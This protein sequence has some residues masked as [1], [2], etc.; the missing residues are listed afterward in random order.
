MRAEAGFEVSFASA[1]SMFFDCLRVARGASDADRWTL[2]SLGE[3]SAQEGEPMKAPRFLVRWLQRRLIN[4]VSLRRAPDVVI[5]GEEKPYLR[6]WFVIPRNPIFN[7]YLHHFLRSD[8]DRALHD[9]PW[10]NCSLLLDGRYLEHTIK[11]GGVNVR[12]LRKAGDIVLRGAKAAHRVELMDPDHESVI[13]IERRPQPCWTLFITG[14]RVREWAFTVLRVGFIGAFSRTLKTA[15]ARSAR[16]VGRIEMRRAHTCWIYE[17]MVEGKTRVSALPPSLF[18]NSFDR[19]SRF[20]LMARGRVRMK[21]R[22]KRRA[23]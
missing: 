15:D 12:T 16:A 9:H 7:I 20:R 1:V 22:A 2:G 18:L 14:L 19:W 10:L 5:G 6:R 17:D 11:A 3:G 13:E 8:D 21:Q 23:A 4:G